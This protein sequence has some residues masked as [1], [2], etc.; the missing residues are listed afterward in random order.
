[1][2]GSKLA[3]R[4]ISFVGTGAALVDGSLVVIGSV[5]DSWMFVRAF[6]EEA[7][8]DVI[9]TQV[10]R[11]ELGEVEDCGVVWALGR[12]FCGPWRALAYR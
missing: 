9:S 4:S 1:M 10:I 12:C 5:E 7:G 2:S 8:H 6:R 3:G 11:W